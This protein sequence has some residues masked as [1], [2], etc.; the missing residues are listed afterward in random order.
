[1]NAGDPAFSATMLSAT[2]NAQL[3]IIDG[4]A[5]PPQAARPSPQERNGT[6]HPYLSK[7]QD[8]EGGD[9]AKAGAG[10]A[11]G[12]GGE[13][14]SLKESRE[15]G[16]DGG[17]NGT[18][19][20]DSEA[21][22]VEASGACLDLLRRQEARIQELERRLRERE[23]PRY[24]RSPARSITPDTSPYRKFVKGRS[25]LEGAAK[26]TPK[27]RPRDSPVDGSDGA[28]LEMTI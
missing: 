10:S 28:T 9:A 22:P 18:A 19:A 15:K 3:A 12:G 27:S 14:S 16:L 17:E 5:G 13:A 2:K 23:Y 21:G 20:L 24:P 11:S 25:S 1:M 4:V 26:M 7:E 8:L 6:A